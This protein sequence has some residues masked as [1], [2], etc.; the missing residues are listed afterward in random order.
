[1]SAACLYSLCGLT[2][3]GLCVVC[4]QLLTP[5]RWAPPG[6]GFICW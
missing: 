1:M 3:L 6:P 2:C 4:T 5:D